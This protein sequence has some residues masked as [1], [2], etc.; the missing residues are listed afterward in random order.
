MNYKMF[1]RHTQN[2]SQIKKYLLNP[3]VKVILL[4]VKMLQEGLFSKYEMPISFQASVDTFQDNF[5][6]IL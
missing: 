2:R 3:Q 1:Q 5:F 4:Q 6:K